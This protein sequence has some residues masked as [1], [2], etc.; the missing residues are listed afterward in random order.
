MSTSRTVSAQ[1]VRKSEG[2]LRLD[3]MECDMILAAEMLVVASLDWV[4]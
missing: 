4:R 2:Y 1:W 3:F